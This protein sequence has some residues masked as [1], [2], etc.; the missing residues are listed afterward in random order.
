MLQLLSGANGE[1]M[2]QGFKGML[3]AMQVTEVTSAHISLFLNRLP[4]SDEQKK[5]AFKMILS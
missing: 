1:Q 2:K 3:Q 5:M 4:L